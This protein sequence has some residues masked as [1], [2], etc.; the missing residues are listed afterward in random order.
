MS[1]DQSVARVHSAESIS[2]A[3]GEEYD[4]DDP[5]NYFTDYVDDQNP[6]GLRKP[7]QEESRTL[8]RTLGHAPYVA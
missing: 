3:G 2:T 5:S 7:T 8:R 4:F 1:K 6:K